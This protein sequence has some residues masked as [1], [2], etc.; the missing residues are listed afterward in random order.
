M[1]FWRSPEFT[2][3]F[4][5][6]ALTASD[7]QII[8]PVIAGSIGTIAVGVAGAWGKLSA[9]YNASNHRKLRDCRDEIA[10][11]KIDLIEAESE[12]EAYHKDRDRLR[13]EVV[14]LRDRIQEKDALISGKDIEIRHREDT[15]RDNTLRIN[16]LSDDVVGQSKAILI[17]MG[18]A[19]P[20]RPK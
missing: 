18:Q 11:M 10:K 5:V 4:F 20:P 12:R 15:I 6:V 19:Q 17:L 14:A 1:A 3:L 13:E 16:K 7:W 8:I 2:A 9:A